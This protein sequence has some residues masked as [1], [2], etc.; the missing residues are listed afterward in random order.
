[1]L[2]RS[3]INP[4]VHTPKKIDLEEDGQTREVYE[5]DNICFEPETYKLIG[6]STPNTENNGHTLLSYKELDRKDLEWC[7]KSMF[8]V[9]GI[10]YTVEEIK[11]CLQESNKSSHKSYLFKSICNQVPEKTAK[12]LIQDYNIICTP[13]ILKKL[14]KMNNINILKSFFRQGYGYYVDFINGEAVKQCIDLNNIKMLEYLLKKAPNS[15]SDVTEL[16]NSIIIHGTFEHYTLALEI[17]GGRTSYET[18]SYAFKSFNQRI[19]Q[20][21]TQRVLTGYNDSNKFLLLVYSIKYLNTQ[22]IDYLTGLNLKPS[23]DI[24]KSLIYSNQHGLLDKVLEYSPKCKTMIEFIKKEHTKD[25]SSG[26]V[27]DYKPV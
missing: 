17:L 13:D 15:R 20:D 6:I 26:K 14:I 12:K 4:F 27:L 5:I 11:K 7:K 24:L 18:I 22:M 19:I 23:E 8:I 2:S 21:I 16:F 1:M 3:Y 10:E 9:P 25:V